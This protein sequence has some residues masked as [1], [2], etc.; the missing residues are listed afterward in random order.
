MM[1]RSAYILVVGI[2]AFVSCQ[3]VKRPEEPTNLI[4]KPTMVKILSESYLMNAARSV[5]N[6]DISNKGIKL[7]SIIYNKY[8][9]DSLQFAKSNAF[10]SADLDVYKE[11]FLEVQQNLV[12]EKELRDTLYSRYKKTQLAIRYQDS[13]DKAKMDSLRIVFPEISKDSL[14]KQFDLLQVFENQKIDSGIDVSPAEFNQD[15]LL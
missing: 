13:V 6:R 14:Q 12:K 2:L 5:A 10:Y 15:S 11:I 4:D 7:D 8:K 9:I 1:N 3:D